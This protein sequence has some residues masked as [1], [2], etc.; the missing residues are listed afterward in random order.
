MQNLFFVSARTNKR[1]HHQ[2]LDNYEQVYPHDRHLTTNAV[3]RKCCLPEK[4]DAKVSAV[5]A[6]SA[7]AKVPA[8]AASPAALDR[9]TVRGRFL[10][11]Y[12]HFKVGAKSPSWTLG[13]DW[14]I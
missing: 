13:V 8:V 9:A 3:I 5:A 12:R 6:S 4:K 2:I 11:T 7:A 1:H 10:D 14:R